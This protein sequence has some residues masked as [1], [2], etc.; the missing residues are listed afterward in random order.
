[1]E[2]I[3]TELQAATNYGGSDNYGKEKSS[4]SREDQSVRRQ[5]SRRPAEDQSARRQRRGNSNV[6]GYL[7]VGG[8][9]SRDGGR[10]NTFQS[11]IANILNSS[12]D[13]QFILEE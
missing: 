10:T 2:L 4:A 1:L 5:V 12:V 6:W 11:W 13:L 7:L 3:E 9:N 8:R